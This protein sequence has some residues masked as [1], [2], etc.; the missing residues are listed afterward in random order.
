MFKIIGVRIKF[1]YYVEQKFKVKIK[2]F[3]VY[4]LNMIILQ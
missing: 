2:S 1:K 3:K 4:N